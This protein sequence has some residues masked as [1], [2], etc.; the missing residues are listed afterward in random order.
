MTFPLSNGSVALVTGA[1][2]GIGAATAATLAEHGAHVLVAGRNTVRG[3]DTVA[4]IRRRGGK[5][6]FLAADLRDAASARSLAQRARQAGGGRVDIL[7]NNAGAYPFRPTHEVTEEEFDAVYDLNVKAKFFLVAELAPAMAERGKGVIV[8][9]STQVASYGVPGM[10]LYGS[11]KAAVNLLT[12][13]WAAEYGPH[14]VR[15]NAVGVGPTRTEGTALMGED[16]DALAA[17]APVGRPATPEEIAS[18]VLYLASDAASFVQGIL[19][20]VDGGRTAV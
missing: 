3:E 20:P 15:V 6:D 16:L 2:S 5:A 14:G 7:V 4:A 12:K 18:A 8:N 13:A 17:Q 9:I 19:L 1:T 11:S 10:S